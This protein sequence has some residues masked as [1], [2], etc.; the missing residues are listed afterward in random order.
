MRG[1]RAAPPRRAGGR[2][3]R[4]GRAPAAIRRGRVGDDPGDPRP[5]PACAA[6]PLALLQA[7]REKSVAVTVQPRCAS[8]IALRPSPAA[9][10]SARP[11]EQV[12]A[13]LGHEPVGLGRPDELRRGVPLVP[14]RRRPC[15]S[16]WSCRTSRRRSWCTVNPFV[17]G[18]V[19]Q[20]RC[21]PEVLGSL[22]LAAP[23]PGPVALRT[24]PARAGLNTPS[25]PSS[26]LAWPR[27]NPPAPAT[28]RR[29]PLRREQQ[30][31]TVPAR[32]PGQRRRGVG[33]RRRH[34]GLADRLADRLGL[35]VAHGQSIGGCPERPRGPTCAPPVRPAMVRRRRPPWRRRSR[36]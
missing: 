6:R 11:G 17:A 36:A 25:R 35:V 24:P 2:P 12:R 8:Q 9:R 32:L 10:S 18:L 13:D 23:P 3:P 1:P 7:D 21:R 16:V 31:P 34:G 33:D 27:A 15:R 19:R 29:P 20:A 22:P 26:A 28:A 4:R 14:P 30:P 5:T